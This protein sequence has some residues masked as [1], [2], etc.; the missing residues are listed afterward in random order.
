M[1]L[2]VSVGLRYHRY[3]ARYKLLFRLVVRDLSNIGVFILIRC[4]HYELYLKK[5][6]SSAFLYWEVKLG[7]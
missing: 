5:I 2:H 4:S 3:V 1:S 6:F 7:T